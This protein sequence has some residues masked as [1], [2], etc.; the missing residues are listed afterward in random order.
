M[1]NMYQET[2]SR[3]TNGSDPGDQSAGTLILSGFPNF[4]NPVENNPR[5][6]FAA[7]EKGCTDR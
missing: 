7:I 1:L 3:L 5:I 2:G 6:E 4:T